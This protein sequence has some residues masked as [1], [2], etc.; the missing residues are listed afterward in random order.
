MEG[1]RGESRKEFRREAYLKL[2]SR[3]SLSPPTPPPTPSLLSLLPLPPRNRSTSFSTE[4]RDKEP[5]PLFRV[6]A[7]PAAFANCNASSKLFFSASLETTKAALNASPAPV[8]ST[9]VDSSSP[10]IDGVETISPQLLTI[11]DPSCPRV[12]MTQRA[13]RSIR[14]FAAWAHAER[15]SQPPRPVRI[16]SSFTFGEI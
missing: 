8:V 7:K 16:S 11:K 1:S 6:A 15:E 14:T 3:T 10:T 13:P 2:F 12:T 9:I 4:E 5:P